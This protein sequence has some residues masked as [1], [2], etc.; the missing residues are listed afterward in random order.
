MNHH[1]IPFQLKQRWLLLLAATLE[2]WSH[3][4]LYMR[5]VYPQEVFTRTRFLSVRCYICRHPSVVAYISN[6]IKVA[7]PSLVQNVANE[8]AF[9]ITDERKRKKGND[10]PDDVVED[11]M[12]TKKMESIELY[13]I[14][15][16][17]D[18]NLPNLNNSLANGSATPLD[19]NE[20]MNQLERA[21]RDMIIR[22]HSL[23]S[24]NMSWTDSVS[25]QLY[26]HIPTEN[27]SCPEL[28]QAFTDGS[29]CESHTKQE[30]NETHDEQ[31]YR[32]GRVTRPLHHIQTH[33]G[34][35]QFIMQRQSR[36]EKK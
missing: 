8:I 36:I 22:V 32:Y 7:V 35:F 2:T 28:N 10:T 18:N 11:F 17:Y 33:I 34:T 21:M 15:L 25:F 30:K 14:R 26:L 20:I 24:S 19:V 23:E 13:K 3:Q 4:L 1:P 6:T 16:S 31:H 9:H 12:E 27:E 5:Q 29:W